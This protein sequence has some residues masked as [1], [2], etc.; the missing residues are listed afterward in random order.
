MYIQEAVG[1]TRGVETMNIQ[2]AITMTHAADNEDTKG[3]SPDMEF[4]KHIQEAINLTLAV[5][6]GHTIVQ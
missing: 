1:L 4:T 3:S 5:D 2:K 6:N